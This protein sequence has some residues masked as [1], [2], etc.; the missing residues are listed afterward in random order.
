MNDIRRPSPG[1]ADF[2]IEADRESIPDHPLERELCHR[3]CAVER[4]LGMIAE[5]QA[6]G[7]D[8]MAENLIAQHEREAR[9]VRRLQVAL[10][11]SS[12]RIS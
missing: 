9:L 12:Q 5:A 10:R 11:N 1:L 8:E 4:Y 6:L 3:L 2:W 7:R